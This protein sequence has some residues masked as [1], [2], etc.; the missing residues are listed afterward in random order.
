MVDPIALW[1]RI[2][3]AAGLLAFV[4]DLE[5]FYGGWLA[6]SCRTEPRLSGRWMFGS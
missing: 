3:G 5:A 1:R 2:S 4:P 6:A